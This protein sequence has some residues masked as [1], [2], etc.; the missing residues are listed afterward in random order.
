MRVSILSK[1][2]Y[3][4]AVW[5]RQGKEGLSGDVIELPMD[6]YLNTNI[7]VMRILNESCPKCERRMGMATCDG[8]AAYEANQ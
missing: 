1:V 2:V 7:Q 3:R 6:K 4:A 5:V 8:R